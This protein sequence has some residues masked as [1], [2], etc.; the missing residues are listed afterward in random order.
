MRI[1]VGSARSGAGVLELR[2]STVAEGAGGVITMTSGRGA[3]SGDVLVGSADSPASGDVGV[4]TGTASESS[5]SILIATGSSTTESGDL[6][7]Q[8]GAGG[9]NVRLTA[10]DSI[11]EEAATLVQDWSLTL[12]R[13]GEV[14]VF[15]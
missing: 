3:T 7:L 12:D 9:G 8:T 13:G 10:G 15:T 6:R 2:G 14:Y 4:T 11:V 5:G 1:G